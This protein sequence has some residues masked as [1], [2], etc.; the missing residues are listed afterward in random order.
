[1]ACV[2]PVHA[3]FVFIWQSSPLSHAA[4]EI[5]VPFGCVVYT[6][7][8][9]HVCVH[10]SSNRLPVGHHFQ[11]L[12]VSISLNIPVNQSSVGM[13]AAHYSANL[14]PHSAV[15]KHCLPV[16]LMII[17]TPSE[18]S[19]VKECWVGEDWKIGFKRGAKFSSDCWL[20][21]SLSVVSSTA[22]GRKKDALG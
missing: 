8:C 1:M 9:V 5:S 2:S 21:S 6:R 22:F 18:A 20:I 11:S 13:R 10:N 7:A 12:P 15:W 17:A 14:C 19:L 4:A 16:A 3:V